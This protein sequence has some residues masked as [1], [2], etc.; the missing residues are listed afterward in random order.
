MSILPIFGKSKEL[1]TAR[2]KRLA[3]ELDE[4]GLRALQMLDGPEA[5]SNSD[6]AVCFR[7]GTARELSRQLKFFLLGS[8]SN[9]RFESSEE[10][11]GRPIVFLFTG[12]GSQF[13]GMGGAIVESCSTIGRSF[14]QIASDFDPLLE[15]PLTDVIFDPKLADSLNQTRYVQPALFA[16][17][18]AV[19][20]FWIGLG[21]RPDFLVGHSLGEIAAASVA[22]S[23]DQ[24]DCVRLVAE[25]SRLM[26]SL[27]P[28]GGMLAVQAPEKDVQVY[29]SGFKNV[30]IAAQNSPMSVVLSG[31]LDD[32]VSIES[33]LS[34]AGI[35]AVS[36]KVSHAFHSV[37]MEPI[38]ET[39]GAFAS[40]IN[41]RE[42][43]Y[44]IVSNLFGRPLNDGEIS[45]AK[46][47]V[48][49]LRSTVRFSDGIRAVSQMGPAI[50]IEVG[51]Q[52][53]LI[54]LAKTCVSAEQR[55]SWLFSMKRGVDDV[56]QFERVA[57][58]LICA[59]VQLDWRLFNSQFTSQV[60]KFALRSKLSSR[61]DSDVLN[62]IRVQ[63]GI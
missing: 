7:Y 26:Q 5:T 28:G 34:K 54:N 3:D 41:Y 50:Y 35:A 9:D 40:R 36:L 8:V 60:V 58:E 33:S 39:F 53:T 4:I 22:N 43:Q 10:M 14:H 52:P 29:L 56:V 20:R 2:V 37:L 38:L 46:Y 63:S 13:S 16:L 49:H 42:P 32:L 19:A 24:I 6:Y 23:M 48:D 55:N 27:P 59:R 12:Q 1:V 15:K 30:S 21:V 47:W 18:S 51:P 57:C 45:G 11:L 31:P 17:E 25:R 61:E 44:K 62:L